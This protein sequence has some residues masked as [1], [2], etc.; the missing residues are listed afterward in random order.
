M[1]EKSRTTKLGL[2]IPKAKDGIIEI[3]MSSFYFQMHHKSMERDP[4]PRFVNVYTVESIPKQF[5]KAKSSSFLRYE[6]CI[7]LLFLLNFD[8]L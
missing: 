1:F 3:Q 7:F 6:F 5:L 8:I 2:P 4:V